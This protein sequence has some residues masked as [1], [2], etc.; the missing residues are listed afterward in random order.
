MDFPE[1]D[2]KLAPKGPHDTAKKGLKIVRIRLVE[3]CQNR[4]LAVAARNE[5]GPQGAVARRLLQL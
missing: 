2:A 5:P 4:S 3:P 1:Q